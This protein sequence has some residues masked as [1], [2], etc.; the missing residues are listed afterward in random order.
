[1]SFKKGAFA[2]WI[3]FDGWRILAVLNRLDINGVEFRMG[4]YA[5]FISHRQQAA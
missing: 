1:M 3:Y 2:V 4:R 5:V